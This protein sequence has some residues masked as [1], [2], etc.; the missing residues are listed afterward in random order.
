M[1]EQQLNEAL[2]ELRREIDNLQLGDQAAK[3]RLSG[4]V[5]NIEQRLNPDLDPG[6]RPDLILEMKDVI[7]QFE[8]A[9]PRI[10]GIVNDIMMALSNLGI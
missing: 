6:E 3:E 9:H 10:T 2:E 5:E 1:S 8:V 4:L 7:T